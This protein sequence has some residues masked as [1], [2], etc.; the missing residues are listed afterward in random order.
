MAAALLRD[1]TSKD[2]ELQNAEIEVRSAGTVASADD[3]AKQLAIQTMEA[4]GLDLRGHQA[5]RL[6]PDLVNWAD[7]I[8]TMTQAHIDHIVGR[9]PAAGSKAFML[10]KYVGVAAEVDDP[11]PVGTQEAY[12]RCA[13]QMC[14]YIASVVSRLRS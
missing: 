12:R 10:A 2:T 8:L 9:V 4:Y 6:T 5:T 7:L 14:A 13:D 11:L 1:A 3:S